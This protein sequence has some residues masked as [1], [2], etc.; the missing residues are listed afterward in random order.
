MLR[1]INQEPLDPPMFFP[2]DN[3]KIEATLTKINS[4]P[5]YEPIKASM[6]YLLL[7]NTGTISW[8]KSLRIRQLMRLGMRARTRLGK[9]I[10]TMLLIM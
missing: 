8:I 2:S 1:E 9:R 7:P 10:G 4:N 3:P 5:E 6:S